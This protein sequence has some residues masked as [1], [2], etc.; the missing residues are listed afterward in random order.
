[1]SP[2]QTTT[3]LKSY[4]ALNCLSS[5]MDQPFLRLHDALELSKV[6]EARL[7]AHLLLFMHDSLVL[8]A[9]LLQVY[10]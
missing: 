9:P 1:M 7:H 5:P 8:L 10:L 3:S 2:N 6:M 4:D